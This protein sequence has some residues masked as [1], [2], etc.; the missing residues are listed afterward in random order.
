MDTPKT[1]RPQLGSTVAF[2]F[3]QRVHATVTAWDAYHVYATDE[4]G[5]RWFA[6]LGDWEVALPLTEET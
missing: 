3:P 6:P 4:L 2:A 5:R 1:P